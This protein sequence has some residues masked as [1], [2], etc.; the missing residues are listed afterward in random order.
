MIADIEGDFMKLQD[1]DT[2]SE[3][4]ILPL[5]NLVLFPG[6]VSPILIGRES[7]T[8][9][10]RKAARRMATSKI[11]VSKIFISMVSSPRL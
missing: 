4:P 1:I 9:L 3:V 7:S 11:L 8:R 10:I 2:P 5:R 6:V